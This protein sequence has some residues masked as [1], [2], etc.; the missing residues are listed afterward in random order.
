I[1]GTNLTHDFSTAYQSTPNEPTFLLFSDPHSLILGPSMEV[2]LTKALSV[3]IDALHRNLQLERGFITP[4][5]QRGTG[6]DPGEIGTWEFPFLL[7]YKIPV[8]GMRPF[9]ELGPSF[10]IR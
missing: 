2:D 4:G 10:R 1:G 3:E 8:S 9:V 7:K 5:G 6:S